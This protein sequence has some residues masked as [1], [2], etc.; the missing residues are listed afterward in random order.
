[1]AYLVL[2]VRWIL[3][4]YV[5]PMVRNTN[6]LNSLTLC[7]N[8]LITC[9]NPHRPMRHLRRSIVRGP[10]HLGKLSYPIAVA[11][12]I[13]IALNHTLSFW[14]LSARRWFAGP[15]KQ[16]AAP[17]LCSFFVDWVSADD[18]W[19]ACT[20][21]RKRWVSGVVEFAVRSDNPKPESTEKST[22]P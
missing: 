5:H 22:G 8:H 14:A 19:S 15:I 21:T 12:A 7:I 11:A 6:S 3:H 17:A 1:M 4:G 20:R 13:R 10:F 9:R 16:V 18:K 2:A